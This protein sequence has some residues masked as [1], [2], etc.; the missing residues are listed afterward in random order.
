MYNV[1]VAVFPL[2]LFEVV[3]LMVPGRLDCFL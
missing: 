3:V 2:D 1:F